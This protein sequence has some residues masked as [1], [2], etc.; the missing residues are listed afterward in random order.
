MGKAAHPVRFSSAQVV[1]IGADA[2]VI[3]LIP[4]LFV[5]AQGVLDPRGFLVLLPLALHA[6]SIAIVFSHALERV[7]LPAWAPLLVAALPLLGAFLPYYVIPFSL[8]QF[9]ALYAFLVGVVLFM[10]TRSLL[11]GAG[12]TLKSFFIVGVL[13]GA[14]LVGGFLLF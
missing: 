6:V 2:F 8:E 1:G 10:A 12:H 13:V 7:R 3:G 14:A 11:E 4:S 5:H 9:Y